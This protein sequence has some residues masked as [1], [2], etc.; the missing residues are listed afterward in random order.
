MVGHRSPSE[1]SNDLV[2]AFHVGYL[3]QISTQLSIMRAE[4]RTEH[5]RQQA[6]QDSH[7]VLTGQ[8]LEAIRA[9]SKS[10]PQPP[11]GPPIL[12]QIKSA[13]DLLGALSK[14]WPVIRWALA[15]N[16]FGWLA[17]HAARLLGWL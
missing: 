14:A 8:V 7:L 16:T 2:S 5:S 10:T 3:K 11:S 13:L 4:I 6:S 12:K 15:L 9:M 17:K 1:T